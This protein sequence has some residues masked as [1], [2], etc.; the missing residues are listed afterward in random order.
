MSPFY[1]SS[2]SY[3]SKL[4]MYLP[5][6]CVLQK[7]LGIWGLPWF[8]PFLLEKLQQL[9][10]GTAAF[11]PPQ[12]NPSFSFPQEGFEEVIL[13][14]VPYN[15]DC[16]KISRYNIK[17]LW[18]YLLHIPLGCISSSTCDYIWEYAVPSF[19]CTFAP[20]PIAFIPECIAPAP[21][22]CPRPIYSLCLSFSLLV[23]FP[24]RKLLPKV[25][26]P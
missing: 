15:L 1:S 7:C 4:I 3:R 12:L 26:D 8:R 25:N 10:M 9:F 24:A 6:G 23:S 21:A 13:L 11:S 17:A 16:V 22:P 14:L 18:I 5:S 2:N 19:F 20:G